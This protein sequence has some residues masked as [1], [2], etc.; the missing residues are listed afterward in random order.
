[1][2]PLQKGYENGFAVEGGELKHINR[3][4]CFKH[5]ES[6]GKEGKRKKKKQHRKCKSKVGW[7]FYS[8]SGGVDVNAH[9]D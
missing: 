6:V 5:S 3:K 1:M 8:L 4:G 7:I 9:Q 2:G